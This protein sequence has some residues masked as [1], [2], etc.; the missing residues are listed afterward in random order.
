M[1]SQSH[2]NVNG[3]PDPRIVFAAERTLLAWVRTGLAAMGF[4]FVVAR[5]GLFLRELATVRNE[6]PTPGHGGSLWLGVVLVLVGVVVLILAGFRYR[7]YTAALMVE[8][9][10]STPT[11][12]FGLIIAGLLAVIGLSMAIY[13]LSVA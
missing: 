11:S 10:P 5:F 3:V 6:T 1:P 12:N 7:R 8:Q 4:G 9:S 13:L 2:Q